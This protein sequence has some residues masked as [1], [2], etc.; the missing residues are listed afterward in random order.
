MLFSLAAFSFVVMSC[1]ESPAEL[2]M[3]GGELH[4]VARYDEAIQSYTK[5][6]IL[7]P[8]YA[9]AYYNRGHAHLEI[10]RPDLAQTDYDDVLRLSPALSNPY[11]TL[12]DYYYSRANTHLEAG[13]LAEA[14]ADYKEA[15]RLNP[16]IPN[17]N[18]D[19]GTFHYSRANA[20]LQAGQ[21]TEA[22]T[23]FNEALRL[24]PA[25]PDPYLTLAVHHYNKGMTYLEKRQYRRAKDNLQNAVSLDP[26]NS[27][28]SER[29]NEIEMIIE[30]WETPSE[31]SP[32]TTAS[33]SGI[34]VSRYS[35]VSAMEQA[36]FTFNPVSRYGNREVVYGESTVQTS[37]GAIATLEL[38]G[39]SN[40]VQNAYF[41]V[42]DV[43]E[44]PQISAAYMITFVKHVLPDW[45]EGPN[46]LSNATKRAINGNEAS[47]KVRGSAGLVFID[48][49][50]NGLTMSIEVSNREIV[51]LADQILKSP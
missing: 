33:T 31:P 12:A 2:V 41:K 29:L 11:P 19:L 16:T 32:V 8:D 1:G 43:H 22:K 23:D 14:E 27:V 46:W 24:N 35:V 4:R 34:G 38:T 36:G 9:M 15:I 50:N 39:P 49:R 3:R 5:A 45:R 40:D 7:D 28:Y 10:G 25:L 48:V 51:D 47:T 20:H 26:A 17:I 18:S 21:L 44:A 37:G 42:F 30:R 6:I 13:R